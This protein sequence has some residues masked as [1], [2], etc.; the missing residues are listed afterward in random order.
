M[1]I[2]F[3]LNKPRLPFRRSGHTRTKFNRIL[4]DRLNTSR[5]EMDPLVFIWRENS[6]QFYNICDDSH[7]SVCNARRFFQ[8]EPIQ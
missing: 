6:C 7:G 4:D 2:N 8:A 1:P 5:S 3:I